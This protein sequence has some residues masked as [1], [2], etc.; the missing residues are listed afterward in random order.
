MVSHHHIHVSPPIQNGL[1]SHGHVQVAADPATFCYCMYC[2]TCGGTIRGRSP[3][4]SGSRTRRYSSSCL[5]LAASNKVSQLCKVNRVCF[6]CDAL[7]QAKF[8]RYNAIP[9]TRPKKLHG[10]FLHHVKR[11]LPCCERWA[12]GTQ[13]ARNATTMQLPN[14]NAILHFKEYPVGVVVIFKYLKKALL[15]VNCAPPDG[16]QYR[17][18]ERRNW[19]LLSF[20]PNSEDDNK[21]NPGQV[22]ILLG[23]SEE[24]RLS[25]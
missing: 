1:K 9:R 19:L 5:H 3:R 14:E 10:L 15:S 12:G 4:C 20:C 25:A 24:P 7:A 2:S 16:A 23:R 6:S 13:T 22:Y 21:R 18:R 11:C 17:R 8:P